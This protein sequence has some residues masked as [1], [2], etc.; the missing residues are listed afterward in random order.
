IA[1]HACGD[2]HLLDYVIFERPGLVALANYGLQVIC[3][4]HLG[5]GDVIHG[6]AERLRVTTQTPIAMQADGDPAGMTP[7]DIEVRPA[8]LQVVATGRGACGRGG[9]GGAMAG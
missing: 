1:R 9:P 8:A 5:R 6:K 2:D 4:R 3:G 7:V